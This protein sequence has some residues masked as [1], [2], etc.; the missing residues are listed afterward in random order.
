MSYLSY[1]Y[2]TWVLLSIFIFKIDSSLSRLI[3]RNFWNVTFSVFGC[4]NYPIYA[5]YGINHDEPFLLSFDLPHRSRLP[6]LFHG[7]YLSLFISIMTMSLEMHRDQSFQLLLLPL[8]SLNHVHSDIGSISNITKRDYIF[9]V[10][11]YPSSN[12]CHS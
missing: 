10:A 12:A 9:S 2:T 7:P 4:L 5:Q 8:L 1:L 3:P 6:Y 11:P